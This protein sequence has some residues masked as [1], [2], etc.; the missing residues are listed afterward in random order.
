MV[1][2]ISRVS[3]TPTYTGFSA[4]A[5]AVTGHYIRG[6]ATLSGWHPA[7]EGYFA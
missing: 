6:K 4:T 2:R 5:S 7:A 3:S 1:Y